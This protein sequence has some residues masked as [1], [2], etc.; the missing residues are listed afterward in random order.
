MSA[1]T[2]SGS[3]IGRLAPHESA[4]RHVTGEALYVDD[5]PEPRGTLHGHA[6]TSPHARARIV[7]IGT[8][9]ARAVP[10]V[11]AVLLAGDVP[12]LNQVGAVVHDE[13]L[14]AEGEVHTEGQAV[15][16]VLAESPRAARLGA[17]AVAVQYQ[18]LPPVL[19]ISEAIAA[20]AFLCEPHVLRRGDPD[21]ALAGAPLRL[22]G[23]VESGGQ[24]HFYLETQCA[25]AVPE[26]GGGLRV[27]SS[28]QHPSE[29]QAKVAEVLGIPRHRVVVEVPRL[30]GGFGG[31]ETQ[32]APFAALASLGVWRTG[33]PVKVWLDRDRDMRQ[34][35]R[36]HPFRTDWEAGFDGEGR[37]LALVARVFADGGWS[38]DLSRAILDRGLF[39]LDNCYHLPALR[40]EGRVVRT[41][42]AS[43][44]AFRGFGGP[45]GVLVVEEVLNRA[46]ER[47]GLDPADVRRLNLYGPAPRDRTPYD[48]PVGDFR[49][50]RMIEALL[51]SSEYRRRREEIETANAASRWTKRGI[52]LQ[53]VK[54]GISFTTAFLNQAGALVLVYADGSVQLNHG[55]VEMG[56]GL[57]TKMRAVCAH[58]LGVPVEAVRVMATSTE[59]VPNT[60]AT[61]AS[62]GSDLNGQ[63]VLE[64]CAAVR[65]RMRPVAATLLGLPAGEEAAL[66]FS[67][68]QVS[69]PGTGLSAPFADVASACW[70]ARISLSATGYYR[71]PGIHY[72]PAVG[73]G[74]PF[75]YFA[76]GAA[77]TEVEVSGLTG[78]HRVLRVDVLHD[79]GASL[80]PT[81]D[82]GQVEGAFVQGL[83]WLTTEELVFDESGHLLTHS[84][85]T[86]KVP[87]IG[88]VPEDFRVDLLPSSPHDGTIHG[89]KAVGEPPLMLAIS[90]VT[91]LRHAVGAFGARGREVE[92]SYPC[93][94]EAVLRAVEAARRDAAP[95]ESPEAA[96]VEAGP[97]P[98][99]PG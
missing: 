9:G 74:R 73:R 62:S 65:E 56:Q 41:N 37:L 71:T 12:G 99:D 95:A 78:E 7:G 68:G 94:P 30:G 91:A 49:A 16:L 42:R 83:G 92:L 18:E 8:E 67:E 89:S 27:F 59:K 2:P 90:A 38:A 50:G 39:H 48:Q 10:G 34:T 55:G 43:N 47:L 1:P 21:A 35:G 69:H 6:V 52:G 22:S 87:A 31:K 93:T 32:A 96:R 79:V 28:T 24:D 11:V 23:R 77:V 63:A 97:R 98:E 88:D 64:A 14:L 5:L 81:V 58:E 54:F 86:Y 57:H 61:A 51:A 25:L 3:P 4:A 82:R 15:A 80:T 29:V 17:E 75:F 84:P 85:S 70:L 53:A 19:G 60:S 36:R 44:T 76:Y 20:G 46:A 13:P 40:F 66:V 26:E 33:R 72:D 45:Q